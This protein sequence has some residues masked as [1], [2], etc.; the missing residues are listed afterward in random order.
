MKPW[1]AP[2]HQPLE[3]ISDHIL[4]T[5]TSLEEWVN[6]NLYVGTQP[7]AEVAPK[8]DYGTPWRREGL[9]IIDRS[10]KRLVRTFQETN[11]HATDMPVACDYLDHIVACVNACAERENK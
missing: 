1:K 2:E 4:N 3:L 10:E 7:S 8:Q 9:T 11:W 6:E 5:I